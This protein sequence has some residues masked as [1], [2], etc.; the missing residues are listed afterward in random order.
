MLPTFMQSFFLFAFARIIFY[1]TKLVNEQAIGKLF[2]NED[3]EGDFGAIT[4]HGSN[5]LE[6]MEIEMS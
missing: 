1:K 3:V 4:R 2:E 6:F 5:S